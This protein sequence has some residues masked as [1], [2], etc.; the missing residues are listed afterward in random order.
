[1]QKSIAL[2]YGDRE[3]IGPEILSKSL[4]DQEIVRLIQEKQILLKIF[5]RKELVSFSEQIEK[6]VHFFAVDSSLEPA[7][8]SFQNLLSATKACLAKK[9]TGLVTGPISKARWLKKELH[10]KGQTEFLQRCSEEFF[11]QKNKVSPLIPQMCFLAKNQESEL[12][13]VL[14]T[15]HLALR[16]VSQEINEQKLQAVLKTSEFF[17]QDKLKIKNPRLG[18]I[19]LNP[20]NGE[21]GELGKEEIRWRSWLQEKKFSNLEGPFSP[22]DLLVKAGRDYLAGKK[23]A[24][25]LY[26][27]PYHDQVLPLIKVISDLKAVN[28]TIGLPFFRTSPDHGTAFELAGKN[29]ADYL[30]FKS[31]L[32]TCI[33]LCDF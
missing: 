18:L 17:L 32:Q 5:G 23:Q 29:Q 33:Q 2:T 11:R 22:D 30:P 6:S 3:G 16:E 1:M 14:I 25:D 8:E 26:L 13:I 27:A 12:R 7:L 24:F 21:E 15:R 20:H 31:A 9:A 28:A 19:S 10:F 4:K